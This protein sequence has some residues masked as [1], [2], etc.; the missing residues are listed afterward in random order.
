MKL[1]LLLIK[2]V[3]QGLTALILVIVG[4]IMYNSPEDNPYRVPEIATACG[5]PEPIEA[6]TP[7]E[8]GQDDMQTATLAPRHSCTG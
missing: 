7:S 5:Y 8:T 2:R 6:Q 4:L 3:L 1:I